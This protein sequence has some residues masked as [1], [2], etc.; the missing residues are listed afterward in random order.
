MNID[1]RIEAI[2]QSVE[3]IASLQK[4]NEKLMAWMIKTMAGLETIVI[5]HEYRLEDFL[6]GRA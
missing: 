5:A 1:E 2:A 6:E 3:L 4:D